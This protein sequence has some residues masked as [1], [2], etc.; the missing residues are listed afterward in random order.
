MSY[1]LAD[2]SSGD[3]LNCTYPLPLLI[4]HSTITRAY[5]FLL[6]SC[7]TLHHFQQPMYDYHVLH[8]PFQYTLF[9]NAHILWRVR[10][11]NKSRKD[12]LWSMVT[13]C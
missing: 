4:L 2:G 9:R 11:Y 6:T 10:V 1:Y 3:N 13:S 8:I 7:K 5:M 12:L